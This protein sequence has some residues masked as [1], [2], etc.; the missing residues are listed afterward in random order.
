MSPRETFGSDGKVCFEN[1]LNRSCLLLS[2]RWHEHSSI[3]VLLQKDV[4]FSGGEFRRDRGPW[5]SLVWRGGCR[6]DGQLACRF[7]ISQ[8][9]FKVPSLQVFS[10]LCSKKL[11][12]MSEVRKENVSSPRPPRAGCS[13]CRD[14]RCWLW[15][16]FAHCRPC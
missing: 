4:F 6:E 11:S 15:Q 2:Y 7:C 12:K 1:L 3:F 13:G 14:P 10:R 8:Q 9:N 16:R 5:R